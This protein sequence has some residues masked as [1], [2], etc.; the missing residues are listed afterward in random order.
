MY[1]SSAWQTMSMPALAV[2][3][4]G[5]ETVTVGSTTA[6]TG[7]SDGWLMPVLTRRPRM[8]STHTGVLSEPV[9]AVVGTATSGLGGRTGGRPWP[10]GRLT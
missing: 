2:T 10:T 5:K 6:S 3:S 1:D 7:R 8:S 4:G 9:P